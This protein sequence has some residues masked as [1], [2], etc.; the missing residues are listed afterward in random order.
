MVRGRDRR[1]SLLL[2]LLPLLVP[3]R[4]TSAPHGE[5][6]VSCAV[7][8]VGKTIGEGGR[9][10]FSGEVEGEPLCGYEELMC[11]EATPFIDL[12]TFECS[13]NARAWAGSNCSSSTNR[14]WDW[15]R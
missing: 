1:R 8:C 3:P 11:H 6:D 2:L 13:G 12:A 10:R 7:S 5:T 15:P 4:Q 14:H 9:G